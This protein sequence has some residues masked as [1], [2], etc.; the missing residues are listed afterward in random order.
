[1]SSNKRLDGL[2]EDDAKMLHEIILALEGVRD[3]LWDSSSDLLS[4]GAVA[5]AYARGAVVAA[6]TQMASNLEGLLRAGERD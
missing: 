2:S 5:E 4:R 1:M 3:K 6:L